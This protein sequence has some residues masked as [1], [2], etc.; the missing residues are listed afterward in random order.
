MIKA[1]FNDLYKDRCS[2]L[3]KQARG[4]QRFCQKSWNLR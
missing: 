2:L 4:T 3:S 1:D